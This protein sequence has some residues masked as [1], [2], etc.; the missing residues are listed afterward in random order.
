MSYFLYKLNSRELSPTADPMPFWLWHYKWGHPQ[1]V[2]FKKKRPLFKDIRIG[3]ILFFALDS[4]LI[5]CTKVLKTE[6]TYVEGDSGPTQ[7]LTID[8]SQIYEFTKKIKLKGQWGDQ[9]KETTALRWK[10]FLR[11]NPAVYDPKILPNFFRKF[12]TRQLSKDD[13]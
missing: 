2:K 8:S 7:L 3:S 10:A 6:K 9:I 11:K 12:A 13:L 5:G 1:T 4:V